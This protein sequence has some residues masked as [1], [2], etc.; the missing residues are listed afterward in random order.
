MKEWLI[1]VIASCV[2]TVVTLLVNCCF[3][4]SDEEPKKEP[5]NTIDETNYVSGDLVNKEQL[6][7][8]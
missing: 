8:E 2:G 4:S 1:F 3:S 6:K 5:L 7:H